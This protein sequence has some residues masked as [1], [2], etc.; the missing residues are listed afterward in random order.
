MLNLKISD[1]DSS[2]NLVLIRAVKEIKIVKALFLKNYLREYY[3]KFKPK[4]WLFEGAN[5]GQYS[6]SSVAKLLSKASKI[7]GIS[8]K[9]TPHMLRHSFATHLLEQGVSLR[10]IQ[11]LLGHGSSKTTEIYTQVSTQEI[12]KIKNPLDDFYKSK[13]S[14]IQSDLGSIVEQNK[15]ITEINTPKGVH[16]Q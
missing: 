5:G 11:T 6:P 4:T 2:R 3:K 7:V 1:L 13:S 15:N 9:V 14:T 12:G 10:R 16:I 8:R